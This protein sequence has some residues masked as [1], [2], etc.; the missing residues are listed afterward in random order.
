VQSVF[1]GS[2]VWDQDL[3]IFCVESTCFLLVNVT[4]LLR[5]VD[6]PSFRLR[7]P[8]DNFH[9]PPAEEIPHTIFGENQLYA[10]SPVRDALKKHFQIKLER[11]LPCVLFNALV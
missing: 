11:P 4:L 8:S 1:Q 2:G 7:P 6:E 9:E 3:R 10:T 5:D